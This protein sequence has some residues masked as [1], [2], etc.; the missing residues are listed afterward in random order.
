MLP[1][2]FRFHLRLS[3]GCEHR[4]GF[5]ENDWEDLSRVPVRPK[6]GAPSS[7][8]LEYG[9]HVTANDRLPS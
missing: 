3:T 9:F 1:C 2:C 6:R 5:G 4:R 8:T 7:R